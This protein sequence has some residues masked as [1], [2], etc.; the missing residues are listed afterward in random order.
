[1]REGRMVG[2]TQACAVPCVPC[3]P[4]CR[5]CVRHFKHLIVGNNSIVNTYDGW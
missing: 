2:M 3:V 4:A 1:M 5:A